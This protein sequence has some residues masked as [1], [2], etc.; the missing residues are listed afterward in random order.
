MPGTFD[1]ESV[2]GQ[3]PDVHPVARHQWATTQDNFEAGFVHTRSRWP[4]EKRRWSFEWPIADRT[5]RDYIL[6]FLQAQQGAAEAWSFE[7]FDEALLRQPPPALVPTVSSSAGGALA[8]RTYYVTVTWSN[9]QG[10][11]TE[12]PE[13][14]ISVAANRL[15]TVTAGNFP[16]GVTG[17]RVYVGTTAGAGTLQ[18]TIT[19]SG[20]TWTEPAS[21]LVAGAQPPSTNTL[22]EI[23]K[24]HFVA[25][26]Y[27]E[28]GGHGSIWQLSVEVAELF[29]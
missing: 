14:A 25:D 12:S 21:G 28:T 17:A 22:A 1:P 20:G 5:T 24:C 7:L 10:E 11:T 13:I 9:D 26:S 23:I 29:G 27:E 2:G 3:R 8:L 16:A 4:H 6:G 18:A 15:L 19:A